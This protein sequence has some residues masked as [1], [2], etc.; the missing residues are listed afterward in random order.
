MAQNVA[1][2]ASKPAGSFDHHTVIQHFE[3]SLP[4]F[5]GYP[6]GLSTISPTKQLIKLD[7]KRCKSRHVTKTGAYELRTH[8]TG[9]YG[10]LIVNKKQAKNIYYEIHCPAKH[11]QG[12]AFEMAKHFPVFC[13]KKGAQDAIKNS[14]A[15]FHFVDCELSA[16]AI[17]NLNAVVRGIRKCQMLRDIPPEELNTI[18]LAAHAIEIAEKHDHVSVEVIAGE[19]LLKRGLN[20]IYAVGRAGVKAPRMVVLKI[21]GSEPELPGVGVIAKGIV[22]DSGGLALKA[23]PNMRTM[24]GDM[25]G[26]GALIGATQAIA[27]MKVKPRKTLYSICC[28][29]E[30]AIGPN[31]F[32]HDD[33]LEMYSGNT[34]EVNNTD[35]EGRLVMSDGIAYATKDLGCKTV[36]DIATL[37]GIARGTTGHNHG[38]ML[39]NCEDMEWLVRKAGLF[40]GE[41]VFPVVYA[42]ECHFFEYNSLVADFKNSVANRDNAQT[43]C[44]GLFV[45]AN[46]KDGFDFDGTWC[47]LDFCAPA[48]MYGY[49]RGTGYPTALMVSV[50]SKVAEFNADF[51]FSDY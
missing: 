8:F 1:V 6:C 48:S 37:T 44:A 5:D 12:I 20:A 34:V 14:S 22:Y 47:H 51:N 25:G 46:L 7:A 15:H 40:C 4:E 13:R 32:R 50:L 39:T 17:E 11:V 36:F 28:I 45:G 33:I 38:A 30:N 18:E 29:A 24:K 19:D 26:C 35:A 2:V 16:A 49:E 41:M 27:E 3:S 23:R 42:P 21:E 10:G 43:S 9:A 31:A